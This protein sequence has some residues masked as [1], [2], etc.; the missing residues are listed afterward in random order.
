MQS[1]PGFRLIASFI[2]L[3]FNLSLPIMLMLPSILG[4]W[5]ESINDLQS[6]AF[7]RFDINGNVLKKAGIL[8]KIFNI[9]RQLVRR[10]L[11][12]DMGLYDT[13]Y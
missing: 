13:F 7:S 10:D 5:D 2:L 9:L 6:A 1:S 11:L 12:A 4:V 8:M 3:Y